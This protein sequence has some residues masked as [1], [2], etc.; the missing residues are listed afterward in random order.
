MGSSAE[1]AWAAI[2][3]D[4][5]HILQHFGAEGPI[6]AGEPAAMTNVPLQLVALAQQPPLPRA[7]WKKLVANMKV[8]RPSIRRPCVQGLEI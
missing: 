1:K 7:T 4:M 2:L 5:Q 3:R 8:I 6:A